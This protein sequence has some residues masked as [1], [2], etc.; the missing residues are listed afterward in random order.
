MKKN[1]LIIG[2]ISIVLSLSLFL[3]GCPAA[4]SNLSLNLKPGSSYTMNILVNQ[5]M[6]QEIEGQ[7]YSTVMNY[8]FAYI[9]E[10]KDDDKDG[11]RQIDVTISDM[12]MEMKMQELGLDISFDTANPTDDEIGNMLGVVVDAKFT[13][14]VDKDGTVIAVDGAEEI[15]NNL[16][17]QAGGDEAK[18]Q[19]LAGMQEVISEDSLKE[20]FG[21]STWINTDEPIEIG[22]TW[23]ETEVSSQD[24]PMEINTKFTLTDIKD[25]LAYITLESDIILSEETVGEEEDLFGMSFAVSGNQT[26]K[27]IVDTETGLVMTGEMSSDITGEI[28]MSF[29]GTEMKMP[30]FIKTTI[31]I[32]T[33]KN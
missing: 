4:N 32:E 28:S 30:M 1:K 6:D 10:G 15:L 19:M 31:N 12:K 23:E 24:M 7:K 18:N 11:N 5:T 20:T 16:I 17:E 14:T 26:G 22:Y 9:L 21:S 2:V 29:D 3:T 25:K 33:V 8:S 13:L 27:I